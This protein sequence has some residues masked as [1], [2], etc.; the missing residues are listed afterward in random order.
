MPRD[1]GRAA[2]ALILLILSAPV[3]PGISVVLAQDEEPFEYIF[4]IQEAFPSLTFE[5]PVKFANDGRGHLYVVERAGRIYSFPNDSTTA[6]TTRFLD[7]RDRVLDKD[8]E[9]GMLGLVFHPN[10]DLNGF[11]YVFYSIDDP[12][13]SRVS[14]FER[15]ESDPAVADPESEVVILEVEKPTPKHNGGDLVFGNDG[16]LYVSLGDGSTGHDTYGNGQNL[17]TLLGSILRID[18][19]NPSDGRNYGIP[20]DNPFAGNVEGY[21]EEIFA[22][23]FRNPW[24][25]SIDGES[26]HIWVA[27]VGE[28]T[29][30]EIDFVEKGGNYGWPIVEGP[31]CYNP[32]ENCSNENLKPPVHAYSHEVGVSVTGGHV[33]RGERV[34][35]LV[36]KYIFADWSGRQI[37]SLD[38]DGRNPYENG[39]EPVVEQ[40]TDGQRFISSFGVDENGELYMLFTFLGKV[41]RFVA[42][43]ATNVEP[44]EV[45][46]TP[47]IGLEVVGPNPSGGRSMVELVLRNGG[48]V[49]A[50]V[51]DVLGREV[52]GLFS[53][54]LAPGAAREITLD[55]SSLPNGVYF[56]HAMSESGVV[57]R[58]FVVAR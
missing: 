27:D 24:R 19:D 21:R 37:W 13:R 5:F 10:Y 52:S 11:F 40:I 47:L 44:P 1:S 57:T 34:P 2:I 30:E 29:W 58:K 7:I 12:I 26:G 4:D 49:K 28:D 23:G 53:G 9:S 25:F 39:V 56:L 55:A 50:A 54:R 45:P 16:Y 41:M 6:D 3:F 31:V 17:T 42:T 18:V 35:E 33:Y 46:D 8:I 14:R 51:F 43:V 38:Y 36:G 32:P 22:Y 48:S 20:P 15:S